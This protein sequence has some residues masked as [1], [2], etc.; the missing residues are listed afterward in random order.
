MSLGMLQGWG[1]W[2][3]LL[4]EKIGWILWDVAA[5]TSWI[6]NRSVVRRPGAFFFYSKPC[7]FDWKK[8]KQHVVFMGTCPEK[9]T[10][11]MRIED[12]NG[13][14][15]DIGNPLR[16]DF[17]TF[18]GQTCLVSFSKIL[19]FVG[20]KGCCRLMTYFSKWYW[21]PPWNEDRPLKIPH[22]SW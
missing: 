12:W 3:F 8:A 22:L 1:G 2:I 7:V 6:M 21:Y 17:P 4:V 5:A 14:M 16:R 20:L 9:P 19:G 10:N 11:F 18:P 15:N 13:E